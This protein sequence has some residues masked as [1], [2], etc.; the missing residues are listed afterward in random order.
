[1]TLV[2]G[3]EQAAGLRQWHQHQYQYQYQQL[4]YQEQLILDELTSSGLSA[5]DSCH[6][7]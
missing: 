6:Q 4:Q 3:Q 2:S 5:D 1:M 7:S